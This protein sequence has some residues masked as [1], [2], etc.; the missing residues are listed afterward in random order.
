MAALAGRVDV[1]L[2]PVGSWGPHLGPG[3]LSPRTAAETA[4]DV[5]ARIAVPIHWGTL[6]PAGLERR[7][8]APLTEPATRFATWAAR[9][10]PE[11]D[12]RV[13]RPGEATTI[14]G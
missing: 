9:V 3:H 8:G 4:R 13:L 11:L 5:R 7:Y 14:R 1:A 10:A 12:V 2:L 6:Y